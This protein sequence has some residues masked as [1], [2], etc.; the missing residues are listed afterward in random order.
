MSADPFSVARRRGKWIYHR[1]ALIQERRFS[2]CRMMF[3]LTIQAHFP[4]A[5]SLLEK[6]ASSLR[7]CCNQTPLRCRMAISLRRKKSEDP[8]SYRIPKDRAARTPRQRRRS[9]VGG[10]KTKARNAPL[11]LQRGEGI[12]HRITERRRKVPFQFED[13]I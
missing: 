10:R 11:R 13:I 8:S 4:V 3:P 2:R 12:F 5:S 7:N 9:L 6:R 1:I